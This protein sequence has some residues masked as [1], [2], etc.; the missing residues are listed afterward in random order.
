MLGVLIGRPIP[1]RREHVDRIG[2]TEF[3]GD[4]PRDSIHLSSVLVDH[5]DDHR[6][7]WRHTRPEHFGD[8][9]HHLLHALQFRLDCLYHRQHDQLGCRGH[10]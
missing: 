7:V 5:H 1:K 3:Q 10:P 6:W 8:G 2:Y 4:E 9:V